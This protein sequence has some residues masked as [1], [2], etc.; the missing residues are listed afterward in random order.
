MKTFA[1]ILSL[2]VLALT[3]IPCIDIHKDMAKKQVEISQNE[4]DTHN[5]GDKD[6]CSPFCTCNCCATSVIFQ[7]QLVQLDSFSFYEKQYFPV[8]ATFFTD[9][10]ASIW[11]PPKI[12]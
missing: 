8:S 7:E 9:P 11:Q 3:A 1:I 5:Q 2:Y 10:L 4:Q 12:A 6:H